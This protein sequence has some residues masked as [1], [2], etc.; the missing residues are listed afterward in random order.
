MRITLFDQHLSRMLKALTNSLK[1]NK[2]VKLHML[3]GAMCNWCIKTHVH[4][5]IGVHQFR[6]LKPLCCHNATD[7]NSNVLQRKNSYFSNLIT[8]SRCRKAVPLLLCPA[9]PPTVTIRV[10]YG[11]FCH[12]FQEDTISHL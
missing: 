1:P 5:Y 9:L 12:C 11:S 7:V 10:V 8:K 6:R 3:R 2:S 4:V